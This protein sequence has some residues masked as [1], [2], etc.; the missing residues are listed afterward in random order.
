MLIIFCDSLTSYA[1]IKQSCELQEFSSNSIELRGMLTELAFPI[2]IACAVSQDKSCLLIAPPKKTLTH[3]LVSL[4]IITAL[5][6]YSNILYVSDTQNDFNTLYAPFSI[7]V[8]TDMPEKIQRP[9]YFD[10]LIDFVNI[11]NIHTVQNTRVHTFFLHAS[12]YYESHRLFYFNM[13]H[14]ISS[15]NTEISSV[16]QENINILARIAPDPHINSN[17]LQWFSEMKELCKLSATESRQLYTLLEGYTQQAQ[18]TL[19]DEVLSLTH[20]KLA[21]AH[22]RKRLFETSKSLLL[23]YLH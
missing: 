2:P 3:E 14:S 21:H 5:F 13:E 1:F 7:S 11:Q 23:E 8:E 10:M 4:G 16:L 20:T 22:E 12:Q 19:P 6:P 9:I 18:P 15:G 17:I